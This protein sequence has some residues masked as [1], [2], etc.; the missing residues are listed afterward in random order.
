MQWRC[1]ICDKVMYEEFRNNHLQ[2]GFHKRLAISIIRKYNI[3]NPKPSKNDDTIRNF[4]GSYYKKYEKIQVILSVKLLMPSKQIKYIKRQYPCH[5]DQ[6][7]INKHP[8][9]IKS[10]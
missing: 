7:C 8:P 1:N 2:S 3:T 6:Q 5:R 10:K 9:S 4:L